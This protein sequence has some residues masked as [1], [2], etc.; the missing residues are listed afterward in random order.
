M[1][2]TPGK[3]LRGGAQRVLKAEQDQNTPTHQDNEMIDHEDTPTERSVKKYD[4][5]APRY[6][7]FNDME[8]DEANNSA[9]F[10]KI[11]RIFF[12][13]MFLYVRRKDWQ[14]SGSSSNTS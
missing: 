5:N 4:F 1:K 6:Q 8:Q 13:D 14:P 3:R 7:D 11:F 2:S 12:I 10:G 9:W